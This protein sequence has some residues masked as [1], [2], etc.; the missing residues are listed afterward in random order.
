MIYLFKCTNCNH[1]FSKDMAVTAY[2]ATTIHF[3]PK[4]K[5]R[6]TK[7]VYYPPNIVYMDGGFTKFNKEKEV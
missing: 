4:C 2:T 1:E 7:R 6:N 5:S 3:C